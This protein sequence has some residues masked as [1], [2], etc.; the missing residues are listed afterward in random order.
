LWVNG[1]FWQSVGRSETGMTHVF[2]R[3]NWPIWPQ[4]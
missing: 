3:L 4:M 2:R 1:V